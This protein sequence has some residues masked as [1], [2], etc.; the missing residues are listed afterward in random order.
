M[1]SLSD[2]LTTPTREEWLQKY[3]SFLAGA[4]FPVASWAKTA[5]VRYFV[6]SE[7]K[8]KEDIGALIKRIAATGFL[9]TAIAEGADFVE[10][11]A[12][13]F[14]D[15][16][17]QPA[18]F[19]QGICALSDVGSVGPDTIQPGTVWV[20]TSDRSKRFSIIGFPDG[21]NIVPLDGSIRVLVQA[22]S[23]G[24]DWNVEN[25]GITEFVTAKP[26]LSISNP[27]DIS[28]TWI[29]QQGA[30]KEGPESLMGRC[31]DKWSTLG[32]GS[33]DEAYR[34]F[35]RTIPE[36]TRVY[37]YSPGEGGVRIIVAGPSGP[38]SSD[39]LDAARA[40]ITSKAP[41]GVPNVTVEN[42][43]V[44]MVNVSGTVFVAKGFDLATV[45]AE[46][47]FAVNE[48]ARSSE[49]GGY[50]DR[51]AIVRA[52]RSPSGVRNTEIVSPSTDLFLS[53]EE[54][55]VPTFSLAV[56]YF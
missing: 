56:A 19:T 9:R 1:P 4:N 47:K 55:F 53:T 28:G 29:T 38:V 50:L 12:Y 24:S 18:T 5:L 33:N 45:L 42:A 26:G 48:L 13:E 8:I 37:P 25:D 34:F 27:A 39:A 10:L 41:L 51:D 40:L 44:R 7:S 35:A 52:V 31:L 36:I 3:S 15:E 49:I 32:T 6:E 11:V 46:S 17:P 14:W 30:D 43:T 54:I 22:E 23:A 16:V 20:A 21:S 2:L